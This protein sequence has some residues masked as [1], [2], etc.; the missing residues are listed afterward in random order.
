MKKMKF[1]S[2]FSMFSRESFV[3]CA[4][5]KRKKERKSAESQHIQEN[6]MENLFQKVDISEPWK[7][8]I[9]SERVAAQAALQSRVLSL[10]A[11]KVESDP[12][13]KVPPGC[14]SCFS[15]SRL[16]VLPRRSDSET[17]PNQGSRPSVSQLRF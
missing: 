12:F 1:H 10:I 14:P 13:E 15:P 7:Y 9:G 8:S 6:I 4:R 2:H 11:A 17:I 3:R 16:S 5:K